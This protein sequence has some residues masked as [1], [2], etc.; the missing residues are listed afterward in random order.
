MNTVR[1]RRGARDSLPSA[2]DIEEP[3]AIEAAPAGPEAAMHDEEKTATPIVDGGAA[4]EPRASVAPA[5]YVGPA[6]A[7]TLAVM[8]PFAAAPVADGWAA[9]AE[10]Q[11]TFARACEEAAAEVTEVTRS[12][13][14]ASSDA[15]LALLDARTYAEAVEIN[16]GLARRNVAA[17]VVGAVRLSEIGVTAL[18]EASRPLFTSLPAPWR[19]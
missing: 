10:L 16:A 6:E 14:A 3:A 17:L 8:P 4:S 18:A 15:A 7:R 5:P 1:S 13:I 9:L 2:P 12:G 19:G 11:A